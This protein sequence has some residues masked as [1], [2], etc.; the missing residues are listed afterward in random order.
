MGYSAKADNSHWS[1]VIGTLPPGLYL[2]N[3]KIVFSGLVVLVSMCARSI[4][5]SLNLTQFQIITFK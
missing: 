4:I 2:C 5:K 3:N 1:L